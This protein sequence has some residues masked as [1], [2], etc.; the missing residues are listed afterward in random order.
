MTKYSHNS[1]L[2]FSS[3]VSALSLLQNRYPQQKREIIEPKHD[4]S[5]INNIRTK[6]YKKIN[7]YYIET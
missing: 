7:E 4:I 3:G 6:T 1:K 5:K 2:Y